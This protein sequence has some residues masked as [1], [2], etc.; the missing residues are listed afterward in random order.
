MNPTNYIIL[1]AADI[2]TVNF[3]EIMESA[4]GTLRY[5]VDN[6]LFLVKY[7]GTPPSFLEGKTLYTHSEIMEILQTAEWSN[8]VGP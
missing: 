7:R 8:G 6:T 3:S 1:E 2:S 5:S 4:P